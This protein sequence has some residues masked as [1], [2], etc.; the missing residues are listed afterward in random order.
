MFAKAVLLGPDAEYIR[1]AKKQLSALDQAFA[2]EAAEKREVRTTT[3]PK[4][5]PKSVGVRQEPTF[6][7]QP[8][9]QIR[10]S[11]GLKKQQRRPP[12]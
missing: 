2:A 5:T 3:T 11:P 6:K 1:D 10:A 4:E 8:G 9:K 7:K 12:P